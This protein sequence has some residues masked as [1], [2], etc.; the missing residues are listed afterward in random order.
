MIRTR[1]ANDL[2]PF[3]QWLYSIELLYFTCPLRS[4]VIDGRFS[5]AATEWRALV[6]L[7][8]YAR[9]IDGLAILS[10]YASCVR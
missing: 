3:S 2:N 5:M 7:I 6:C 9:V 4:F 10:C 8:A 1:M